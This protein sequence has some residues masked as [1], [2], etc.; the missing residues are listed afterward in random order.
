LALTDVLLFSPLIVWPD[1]AR[2]ALS[3]VG[4]EFQI[5]KNRSHPE[6]VA[7]SHLNKEKLSLHRS[8]P[9]VIPNGR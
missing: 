1:R 8:V 3:V 5:W 9:V 6:K 4:A 7:P 2:P